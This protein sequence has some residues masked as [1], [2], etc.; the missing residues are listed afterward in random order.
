MPVIAVSHEADLSA[1]STSKDGPHASA[2]ILSLQPRPAPK[3]LEALEFWDELF[4]VAMTQLIR[5]H[6]KE[7][8]HVASTGQ[9]IR[10][11]SS[12]TQ[13]YDQVE[14]ARDEYCKSN[15]TFRAGFRKVYRKFGDHAAEPLNRVTK[16][17]PSGGDLGALAVTPIIGCVQIFL[18]V[19]NFP[20]YR[21]SW[22]Q[23]PSES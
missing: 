7:P 17:V 6:P 12:W 8:E 10:Q 11:A 4:P 5:T 3:T 16:L 9:S 19:C 18:E 13:V 22:F 23:Q 14:K 21:V 20:W 15:G 1:E 2:R